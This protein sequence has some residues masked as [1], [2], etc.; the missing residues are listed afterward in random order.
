MKPWQRIVGYVVVGGLLAVFF[1]LVLADLKDRVSEAEQ[2]ATQA[3][4]ATDESKTLAAENKRA[5]QRLAAQVERLGGDP[6]IDPGDL[7]GPPG[8]Q[9]PQGVAGPPPTD[10]QVAQAVR[11]FCADGSCRGSDG[12][13][14]T[15][16]QVAVAVAAYCDYRGECAG[17][18]GRTGET[19]P[20]GP[21][22]TDEQ[23]AQA[24]ATYCAD[25]R[26]RGEQGPR[27]VGIAD[28][29][30]ESTTPLELVITY[31]DGTTQTVTCGGV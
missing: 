27:G 16:A 24:V 31:T 2:T 25:G 5:A 28:L 13:G 14:V 10:E 26:C 12:A 30:C 1:V 15:R 9:G 21:G 19:G 3:R 8:P 7:V 22:P 11:A 29:D 18:T 6:V 20:Q 23:V 17:P 4:D